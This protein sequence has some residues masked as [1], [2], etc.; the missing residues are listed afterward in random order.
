MT[1]RIGTYLVG[2]ILATAL[3]A[4]QAQAQPFPGM[5]SGVVAI[6]LATLAAVLGVLA[7]VVSLRLRRMSKTTSSYQ[8]LFLQSSEGVM[9][10]NDKGAIIDAN[11]MATEILGFSRDELVGSSGASLWHPDELGDVTKDL[12]QLATGDPVRMERRLRSKKERY[13]LVQMSIKRLSAGVTQVMFSDLTRKKRTEAMLKKANQDLSMMYE[14]IFEAHEREYEINQELLCEMEARKKVESVLRERE[15]TMQGVFRAAPVGIGLVDSQQVLGWTNPMLQELLG[16]STRE[17]DGMNMADLFVSPEEFESVSRRGYAQLLESGAGS[18]E[19]RLKT[20]EGVHVD[21]ILN[22]A[23]VDPGEPSG[24]TVVTVLDIS[25]RIQAE[26]ERDDL[27]LLRHVFFDRSSMGELLVDPQS[28]LMTEANTAACDLLGLSFEQ[29]STTPV[30]AM[31]MGAGNPNMDI[32]AILSGEKDSFQVQVR[33]K[34]ERRDLQIHSCP[35]QLQGKTMMYGLLQDVTDQIR[36]ERELKDAMDKANAASRAKS[37]FLANIS[38]ELRTPLHGVMGMI[39]LLGDTPLSEEQTQYM[40]AAITAGKGLTTL[41]ADIIQF[42]EIEAGQIVVVDREFPLGQIVRDIANVFRV[43]CEKKG[44]SFTLDLDKSLPDMLVGDSSRVRQILF[45]LVGNA[46]RFTNSGGV[47]LTVNREEMTDDPRRVPVLFTIADTGPGIPAEK[48]EQVLAPFS[49][50]DNS[51][52]RHHDGSG[53][54]LTIVHRLLP[55]MGGSLKLESEP[56]KGTKVFVSLPFA[57]NA[58]TEAS[59]SPEGNRSGLSVLVADDNRVDRM[60][61]CRFLEKLGHQVTCVPDG[62]GVMEALEAKPFDC[63]FLDIEMPAPD[64]LDTAKIIRSHSGESYDPGVPL[65]ALTAHAMKEEQDKFLLAGMDAY[66]PKPVSPD[67][68]ADILQRVV[69]PLTK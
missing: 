13:V 49:Q 12:A 54:G 26:M 47:T 46:V 28:G 62:R 60:A 5:D 4:D 22:S 9:L 43:E 66:L 7:V 57:T 58:G 65:V 45:N 53:L 14:K 55:I 29:L 3:W 63:V 30:G 16:Y 25:E 59:E 11:P 51:L 27:A 2:S 24:A 36:T 32:P 56:G 35:V 44:L 17:L 37:E 8:T 69:R 52:T 19:T 42:A 15:A 39:H 23:L 67:D 38:H 31:L 10:T 21:V 61:S 64:G 6:G 48:M 40:E 34:G 1:Q 20:K 18:M 50:A 41:L 68:I 33:V